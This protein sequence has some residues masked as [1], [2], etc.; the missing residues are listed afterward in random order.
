MANQSKASKIQQKQYSCRKLTK[1]YSPPPNP[2][3]PLQSHRLASDL[4]Q[5]ASWGGMECDWVDL[6]HRSRVGAVVNSAADL[7]H[8]HIH[9]V[10]LASSFRVDWPRKGESEHGGYSLENGMANVFA[11]FRHVGPVLRNVGS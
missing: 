6:L 9:I 5:S 8:S 2:N 10:E 7:L 11:E 3:I 1:K 4:G